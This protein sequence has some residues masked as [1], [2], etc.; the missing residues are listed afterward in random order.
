LVLVA[1]APFSSGLRAVPAGQ[2]ASD[3]KY[4]QKI[5]PGFWNIRSPFEMFKFEVGTHMALA[6]LGDGSF[7]AIDTVNLTLPG[8]KEEIDTLT[9]NGTKITAVLATH[10]FHT[11]FFPGFH[12]AYPATA[13]RQ[14]FGMPRHLRNLPE[15][16]W[17]GPIMSV[18]TKWPELEMLIPEGGEYDDPKPP[19]SNHLMNVFVFHKQSKTVFN[20]DCVYHIQRKDLGWFGKFMSWFVKA[21]KP[22]MHFHPSLTGPGLYHT[23]EAPFKFQMSI[24]KILTWD[25]E[26]L[27]TAHNSN[28]IG[29]AKQELRELLERTMKKLQ[30]LSNKYAKGEKPEQMRDWSD[31]NGGECG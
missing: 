27:C 11:L 8:L 6:E 2:D 9:E 13:S 14:Y 5:G 18:F 24:E 25:F 17:S 4:L 12:S 28:S 10:P 3:F 21:V 26:N 30:Q 22:G 7:V 23:A 20:D 16:A 1:G 31:R 19:N 15:I 29:T